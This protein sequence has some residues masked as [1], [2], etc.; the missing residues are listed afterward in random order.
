MRA[1]FFRLY[2]ER[3]PRDLFA[4]L[5]YIIQ[6]Q[7]WEFLSNTFWLKHAVALLFDCLHME[8]PVTLAYNSAHVPQLFD[9]NESL[10]LPTKD[11][12]GGGTSAENEPAEDDSAVKDVAVPEATETLLRDHL[13]FLKEESGLRSESL[14]SCLI[15]QVQTDPLVAHHLW[16][17]LFPIV[18][19]IARK[20]ATDG[21]RQAD[22]PSPV[23][24]APHPPVLTSSHRWSDIVGRDQHVPA[25]AKDTG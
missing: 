8:D 13:R 4:R 12:S 10:I 25:A 21:S 16:V 20:R 18:W 17:L 2:S 6:T 14:V 7:E 19:D 1:K 22:H 9:Y 23:Q 5:R 15:E 3:I 11:K 24:G